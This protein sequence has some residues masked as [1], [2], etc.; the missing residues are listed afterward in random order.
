MKV[1]WI[2]VLCLLALMAVPVLAQHEHGTKPP[3]GKA[4]EGMPAM[5]SPEM[6]AMMKAMSPG[7]EHKNMSRMTGDWTFTN[8]MYMPG[9]P[10]SEGAGTMHAE[11]ILGGRYVHSVWK[12][13]FMGMQFEGHGTDGYDNMTKKYVSSWVD[14]MGTGIMYSTGTCDAAGKVC[15]STAEMLDPM[16]G[17]MTTTRSVVTWNGDKSFTMEMYAKPTGGTETKSMEITATKK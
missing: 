5:D 13:D 1:R 12:G 2:A 17:Q 9:A 15:T 14:N 8:K 10:P 6:Q 7:P 16:S 11:M 4:P 3:E